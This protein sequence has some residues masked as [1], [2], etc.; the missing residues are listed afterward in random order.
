MTSRKV[1][2]RNIANDILNADMIGSLDSVYGRT[3][4]EFVVIMDEQLIFNGSH[5]LSDS[6]RNEFFA[7]R[8]KIENEIKEFAT[9]TELIPTPDTKEKL[10]N[11]GMNYY[12]NYYSKG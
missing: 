1:L 9:A 3:K 4:V 12:Q 11:A 8:E 6:L 7:L 10:I 2:I 5:Q